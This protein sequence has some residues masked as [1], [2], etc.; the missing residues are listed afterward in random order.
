MDARSG[1]DRERGGSGSSGRRLAQCLWILVLTLT[2]VLA[3][4]NL[5]RGSLNQ[6]EG[7]YLY[8]GRM[9]S[10][11]LF[12]YRDFAFTQGPVMAFV[13]SLATPMVDAMGLAGGRLFSMLLGLV[14]AV[15]A[16]L[17]A[18]QLARDCGEGGR[19]SAAMLAFILIGLNAYQ[20]YF[21]SVVKTYSL[22]A[23]FLISG[24][25]VLSCARGRLARV[26]A[27]VA[28][29]AMGM[30]AGTRL[31]AA[32]VLPIVFF[33]LVRAAM[34]SR[35]MQG[36]EHPGVT[37]SVPLWFALG[38]VL[39]CVVVFLPFLI[40]VPESMFF[41]VARYHAGRDAGGLGSLLLLKVGSLARLIGAYFVAFLMLV[42]VLA[43]VVLRRVHR[44]SLSG[45]VTEKAAPVPDKVGVRH[46]L[47]G[48]LWISLVSMFVLHMSAPFPYDE[49]QVMVFPLFA[50]GISVWVI[51]L[52]RSA[53]VRQGVLLVVVVGSL[54]AVGASPVTQSW[55][56]RDI[57]RLWLR[58]REEAPLARLQRVGRELKSRLGED[59]IL[60]TQDP[61]LAVE[62]GAQLPRGFEMGQFS[63]FP[64]LTK[65]QAARY[66]VLNRE[67]LR[68]QLRTCPAR[69]AA[70]SGYGLAVQ[71]PQ[72][73]E[74]SQVEQNELRAIVHER[75]DRVDTVHHFGQ[76]ETTLTIYERR[77]SDE[78]SDR[79]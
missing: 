7:W 26:A 46:A 4:A 40:T 16:A 70:F 23:T 72:V 63:Y 1:M 66:N 49:Y 50:V 17:L 15:C 6:D 76:A 13:Y 3:V 28:G 32:L 25:L 57:D 35:K 29:I 56:I 43:L 52:V 61:Y 44:G 64:E 19:R 10:Q 77:K 37:L 71:S 79:R 48:A 11:G 75:F 74:L 9:V 2:V 47:V 22:A 20:S 33:V 31:S 51:R 36:G 60:L 34:K 14:C 59:D 8:A 21:F 27:L 53:S 24:F 12:P 39:T 78:T 68:D 54:G 65:A 67:M 42:S 30:A 18:G 38:G 73:T 58:Q 62:T 45:S 5:R 41:C 55:V 69:V